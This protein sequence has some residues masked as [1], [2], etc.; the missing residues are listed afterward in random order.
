MALERWEDRNYIPIINHL[1]CY[2]MP[3]SGIQFVEQRGRKLL[4]VS[5]DGEEHEIYGKM[6]DVEDY[7]S[8]PPFYRVMKSL[9]INMD[10]IVRVDRDQIVLNAGI[11]YAIGRNNL[12]RLR[13]EY[14]NYLMNRKSADGQEAD[15][16][17]EA[18]ETTPGEYELNMHRIIAAESMHL[19]EYPAESGK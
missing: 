13:R 12:I 14:K 15:R 19:E 1:S 11:V 16:N 10:M 6:E 5:K 17:R 7:L 8:G 4:F 3:V 18:C 9:V 2:R